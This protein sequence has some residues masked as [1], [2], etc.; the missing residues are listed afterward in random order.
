MSVCVCVFECEC[1]L[2]ERMKFVLY[3]TFAKEQLNPPSVERAEQ[4]E[5]SSLCILILYNHV[6]H[7]VLNM[8][9]HR[10]KVIIF[11]AV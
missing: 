5:Y 2:S 7:K 3:V 6:L 1:V 9:T 8:Q 11:Q 10:V 4:K